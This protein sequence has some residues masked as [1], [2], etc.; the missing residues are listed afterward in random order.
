[1]SLF[2]PPFKNMKRCVTVE[3]IPTDIPESRTPPNKKAG[4]PRPGNPAVFR[5]MSV[6]CSSALVFIINHQSSIFN[7]KA[8]G[9]PSPSHGG[10]GFFRMK[11]PAL[12]AGLYRTNPF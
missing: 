11:I 12:F 5:L 4:S 10:F 3:I 9:F 2:I 6:E 7:P 8:R 1:M